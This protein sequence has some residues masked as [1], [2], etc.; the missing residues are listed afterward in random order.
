MST[1]NLPAAPDHGARAHHKFSMSKLNH[2]DPSVGGCRG[3]KGREGTSLAAEEGTA[4]HEITERVVREYLAAPRTGGVGIAAFAAARRNW[5]DDADGLL[6]YCFSYLEGVLTA[7]AKVF[8]ELKARVRR[9]DGTEVN[10][11]HLDLFVLYPNGSAKLVD[12]KFGYSPVLPASE[13]RQGLGY[14]AAMFQTFP[15]A[16]SI[17]VVFV[18]PRLRWVTRHTYQR[19]QAAEMAYRV[20]R[21]VQGAIDVQGEEGQR[22]LLADL[23]NPGAACEYCSRVGTCPGYLQTYSLAVQRMG[24]MSLPTTLDLDAID[25]PEKAAIARAWVDFVDLA[26]GPIKERAMEFARVN[27]GSIEVSGPNG[28]TI[29]YDVQSKQLPRELGSAPE[30]ADVLKDFVAPQQLLGAAK[31]GLEKTLEIAAPALLE[32]QPDV[33]TKKAAREAVISLLESHGLVTRPDGKVEF[34]KR[35]KT[36]KK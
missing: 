36:P 19:T 17:E 26:S 35:T 3:Y 14:A 29:R 10:Y 33:G 32:V 16:R 13:N 6:R 28:E 5:D 34:L 7:G 21:I 1:T 9:D 20:D 8:I 31:L 12:W 30:I 22:P 27:G 15:D 2:L 18:Q 4:L 23:L 25:T 24:G 11:G